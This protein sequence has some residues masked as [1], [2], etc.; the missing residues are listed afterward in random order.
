MLLRKKSLLKR[1]AFLVNLPQSLPLAWKLLKDR[2]LPL[3][4]KLFFTGLSLAYLIF[5][6]DLIP[7]IPI[8]GQLDDFTV[9][10]FLFNWFLNKVPSEILQEYGW[11]KE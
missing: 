11:K 5:P 7:D 3:A 2:R 8:L 9:F 1:I 10:M 6:Y 4:N